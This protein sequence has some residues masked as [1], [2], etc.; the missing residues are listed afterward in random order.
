MVK[1]MK[2]RKETLRHYWQNGKKIR[3]KTYSIWHG[4]RQRCL[5]K[6]NQSSK[7]YKNRGISICQRWIDS[8]EA[9]LED[10]GECPDGMSI[11]RIDNNKGYSP[12]NCRWATWKEQARNKRNNRW[13]FIKGHK[14]L[15]KDV[16]LIIDIK[17]QTLDS[18][19]RYYNYQITPTEALMFY[20]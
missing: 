9:F 4:M 7:N 17:Y 2:G 18:R 3:K 15:L 13:V 1:A 14:H 5:H 19:I 8:F 12:N 16:C 20:L 10:M 6:K 11:D